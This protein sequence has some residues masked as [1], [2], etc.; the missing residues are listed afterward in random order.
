[1]RSVMQCAESGEGLPTRPP[2]QPVRL[3]CPTASGSMRTDDPTEAS[4]ANAGATRSTRLCAL[5]EL[6][7]IVGGVGAFALHQ[8]E[9]RPRATRRPPSLPP[10][11][12]RSMM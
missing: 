4:D 3:V 1:M 10:S 6:A 7:E 12:R 5:H 11:G 2:G 8:I 9:G